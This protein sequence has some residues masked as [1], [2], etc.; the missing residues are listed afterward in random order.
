MK[1]SIYVNEYNLNFGDTIIT[2]N[3]N[4]GFERITAEFLKENS[5]FTFKIT[6]KQ[7]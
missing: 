1:A 5:I 2:R 3:H 6:R 7:S 4:N